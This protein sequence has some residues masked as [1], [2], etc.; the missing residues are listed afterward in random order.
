MAAKNP[1]SPRPQPET[2]ACPL[3]GASV[4]VLQR[5][6]ENGEFHVEGYSEHCHACQIGIHTGSWSD[7]INRAFEARAQ[8]IGAR[9]PKDRRAVLD[10]AFEEVAA[11]AATKGVTLERQPEQAPPAAREVSRQARLLPRLAAARE[12]LEEATFAH[13]HMIG[14]SEAGGALDGASW[15]RLLA[16]YNESEEVYRTVLREWLASPDNP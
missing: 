3:C 7:V 1:K 16:W 11:I 14:L 6:D 4:N 10:G 2:P 8:R 13:D 15:D 9:E 12:Q 5:R